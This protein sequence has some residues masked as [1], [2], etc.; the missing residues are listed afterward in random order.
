MGA[1]PWRENPLTWYRRRGLDHVTRGSRSTPPKTPQYSHSTL[2]LS[3]VIENINGMFLLSNDVSVSLWVAEGSKEK[4]KKLKG[5]LWKIEHVFVALRSCL[6]H[7]QFPLFV[8]FFPS[9]QKLHEI[10]FQTPIKWTESG[11]LGPAITTLRPER[12]TIPALLV[13]HRF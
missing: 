2:P 9:C 6:L 3:D 1:G 4:K 5:L 7:Q 8:I 11:L 12:F 13:K 10:H